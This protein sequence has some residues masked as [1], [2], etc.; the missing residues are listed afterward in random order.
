MRSWSLTHLSDGELRRDLSSAVAR[1]RTSTA[2]LLAHI[3]EFDARKLY[4]AEGYA[5]MQAYCVGA[6]KLSRDATWKRTQ[7]AR[8]ALRFPQLL[9]ALA[10]GRLHLSGACLLVPRLTDQNVDE[11]L[12]AAA[13]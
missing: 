7:A 6:L 12:S 4:V 5:S 11:L 13:D 8:A 2:V 1:E 9:E 10:D 3:A